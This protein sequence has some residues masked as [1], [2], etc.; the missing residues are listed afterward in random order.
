MGHLP[1]YIWTL[2]GVKETR[3]LS[4]TQGAARI[5]GQ[6]V[7]VPPFKESLSILSL[8]L[9]AIPSH[10]FAHGR[11]HRHPNAHELTLY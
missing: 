2:I 9:T 4:A 10:P 8:D 11:Q 5:Q 6:Q 3:G 7:K 1:N